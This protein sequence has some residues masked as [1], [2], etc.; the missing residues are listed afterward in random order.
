MG[1]KKSQ[2]INKKKK[3]RP[4]KRLGAG[5]NNPVRPSELQRERYSKERKNP[6]FLIWARPAT[7]KH[8]VVL[9]RGKDLQQQTENKL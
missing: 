2:K 7:R 3:G 9:D 6:N 5:K 1:K 4:Q 8:S